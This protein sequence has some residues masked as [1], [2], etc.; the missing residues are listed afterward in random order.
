ME[1][2]TPRVGEVGDPVARHYDLQVRKEEAP[3]EVMTG[4]ENSAGSRG[5][6]FSP[7]KSGHPASQ[8]D[9]TLGCHRCNLK[10]TI[11][12]ESIAPGQVNRF[13][14]IDGT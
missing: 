6:H 7:M 1:S 13:L 4:A 2:E 14:V 5:L 3:A 12:L 9:T 10:S 8:I 11:G